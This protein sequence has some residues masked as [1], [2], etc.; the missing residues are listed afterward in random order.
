MATKAN[1][2]S[3]VSL[4]ERLVYFSTRHPTSDYAKGS[5][6]HDPAIAEK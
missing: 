4:F 1:D 5:T 2:L 6:G 3:F